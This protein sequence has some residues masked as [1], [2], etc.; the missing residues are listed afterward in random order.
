MHRTI[1]ASTH[2]A[3]SRK[4]YIAICICLRAS[5]MAPCC[6]WMTYSQDHWP[7]MKR[8]R[9]TGQRFWPQRLVKVF[10][11]NPLLSFEGCWFLFSTWLLSPPPLS[12]IL[13]DYLSSTD[14]LA[15]QSNL[16]SIVYSLAP[17]KN[18]SFSCTALW[19]TPELCSLN[20]KCWTQTPLQKIWTYHPQRHAYNSPYTSSISLH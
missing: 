17:V 10:K 16:K 15:A 3:Q 8:Q 6:W 1:Y 5:F 20:A 12:T 2:G 19:F 13:Q 11:L 18:L 7:E 4:A 9:N 14:E